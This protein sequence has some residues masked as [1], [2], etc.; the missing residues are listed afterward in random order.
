M[1]HLM[2]KP[3][4]QLFAEDGNDQNNGNNNP[5]EALLL[6]KI[7]QLEKRIDEQDKTI[8]SV[9]EF[10]RKLLDGAKPETADESDAKKR[11][12]EFMNS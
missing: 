2:I 10:N 5:N 6:D 4:L 9:T 11:F 12:K 3:Q 8:K 7:K 1:T